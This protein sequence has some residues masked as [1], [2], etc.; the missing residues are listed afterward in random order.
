MTRTM[1]WTEQ[2]DIPYEDLPPWCLEMPEDGDWATHDATDI[3]TPPSSEPLLDRLIGAERAVLTLAET[4]KVMGISESSARRAEARGQ[5]PSIRI[6]RKI[7]V[8]TLALRRLLGDVDVGP[9][10]D[11]DVSVVSPVQVQK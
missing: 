1:R 3:V 11:H 6:N 8:P 9:P 5:I 7:L 10:S 4:A 2:I